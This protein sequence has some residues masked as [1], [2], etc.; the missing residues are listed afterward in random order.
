[1]IRLIFLIVFATLVS[2]PS[3]SQ[4]RNEKFIDSLTLELSKSSALI[5]NLEKSEERYQ[6][7]LLSKE[8]SLRSLETKD[9]VLQS[10]LAIQAFKFNRDYE[11]SFYDIEIYNSLYLA[12]K[13]FNDPF[14]DELPLKID[15]NDKNLPN[16]TYIMANKLCSYLKR[17]MYLRE[18]ELYASHLKI[19]RTCPLNDS[20]L[21]K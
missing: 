9:S 18:W 14:L 3:I 13:R 12:L 11:G 5:I 10:L 6:Y 15:L 8:M 7:L 17:N 1:M 20:R 4:T 16:K 19:E 21:K 2:I